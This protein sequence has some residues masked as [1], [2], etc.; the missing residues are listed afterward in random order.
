MEIVGEER[1]G[2]ASIFIFKCKI[3]NVTQRISSYEN[4]SEDVDINTGIVLGAV[5]S[6]TGYSQCNELFATINVPFMAPTTFITKERN[7]ASTIHN[8]ALKVMAEA[9]Q[10]EATLAKEL[11]EVDGEGIPCITVIAD[12]AWSKRSY[13]VNYNAAS[14][15]VSS[16]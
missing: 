9:G 10:E 11:G 7:L 6:G 5:S 3:C 15:V 14:G 12:G 8:T 4:N 1:H 13:N 16:V 2:L